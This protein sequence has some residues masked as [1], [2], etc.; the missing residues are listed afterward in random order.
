L[1]PAPLA[2][3][4]DAVAAIDPAA[5]DGMVD[6]LAQAQRIVCYGVGREGLMMRALAMRLYHMGLDAHVA[7]DMSC[8][9][10]GPATCWWSAPAPA[11]S[12]PST[13]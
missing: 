12:P 9:P 5:M 11:G 3:I 10:V 6:D 1:P 2:E 8:P 7:G 13:A 4:R